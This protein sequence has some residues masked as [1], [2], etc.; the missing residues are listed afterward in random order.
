MT[1]LYKVR[2]GRLIRA[3]RRPLA[4]EDMI[5][6]WV[7]LDLRLV[8]L[9]AILL[10]QKVRTAHD[11]EIDILAMDRDGGLIIIELKRD[12]TPR[13]IVAQVLDYASWVCQLTTKEIYD[14]ARRHLAV[15]LAETY[16]RQFGQS[17]P[18]TLNATHQMLIVASEFDEASKRIVE[19]LS[20]EHDIGINAVFF[21]VFEQDG[22]EWLT[23]DTLLDQEDVA[24]RAVK[25]ARGPW[26]G[27]FYVTGG[28]EEM[29]PW[30]DMRQHGFFTANGGKRYSDALSR[31]NVDDKIFYYQVNN[32][33]LGYGQVKSTRVPASEFRLSDGS[34]LTQ[35]LPKPY[36][37]DHADD[38]ER[39]AYVVGVEWI[40]TFDRDSA[41]TFPGI[42]ANQNLVCKIYKQDTADFLVREFGI[43]HG[44][45]QQG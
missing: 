43:A 4:L 29:R 45:A 30:E 17:I 44:G 28:P 13:E 33:Y 16:Q 38:P 18:D 36:L 8:G 26:T 41:K 14:I 5:Q 6:N 24:D 42:F 11:K 34:V 22:E 12:R 27:Y 39:A 3:T 7:A 2:D 19:Y 31:L 23:S 25:K 40:K 9:D 32:G 10:G 35:A 15:T 37:I 21:N 1:Q 20:E